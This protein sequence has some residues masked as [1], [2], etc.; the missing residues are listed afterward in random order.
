MLFLDPE[1]DGS[2]QT[3]VQ[4]W[5]F[6]SKGVRSLYAWLDAKYANSIQLKPEEEAIALL[7]LY[8]GINAGPYDQ[9]YLTYIED[10]AYD[11]LDR[12]SASK[13][14][15][16]LMAQIATANEDPDLQQSVAASLSTWDKSH[17]TQEDKYLLELMQP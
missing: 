2:V 9:N 14:K 3:Q 6:A 13:S 11:L 12:L 17:L 8:C 7:S 4:N 10:R 5:T 15:T 1:N 16:H